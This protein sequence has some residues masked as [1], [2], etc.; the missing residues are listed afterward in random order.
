[1]RHGVGGGGDF[2]KSHYTGSI[3]EH[4]RKINVTAFRSYTPLD[5]FQLVMWIFMT[6]SVSH[7]RMKMPNEFNCY[8]LLEPRRQGI[9]LERTTFPI[10]RRNSQGSSEN[11][12]TDFLLDLDSLWELIFRSWHFRFSRLWRF[13][14]RWHRVTMWWDSTVSENLA[15]SVLKPCS[16]AVTESQFATPR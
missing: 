2:P 3:F 12:Q 4:G 7:R 11:F 15:A 14:L 5:T 13:K 6:D 9:L 8:S 10:T 16:A 1:M